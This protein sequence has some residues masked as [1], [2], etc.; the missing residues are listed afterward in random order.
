MK[1]GLF[2][3]ILIIISLLTIFALLI[4]PDLLNNPSHRFSSMM[5]RENIWHPFLYTF[6][7]YAII[8][9]IRLFVALLK[10]LFYS[11]H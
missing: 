7:L 2:R 5:E 11:R 6:L 8:T 10:R 3:E 4:H 1:S 9:I